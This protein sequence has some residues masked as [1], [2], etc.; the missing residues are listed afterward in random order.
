MGHVW[1][2][3]WQGATDQRTWFDLGFLPIAADKAPTDVYHAKGARVSQN[4]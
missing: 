4:H 1:A 3:P 2:A